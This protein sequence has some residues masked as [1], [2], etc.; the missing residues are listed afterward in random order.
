MSLSVAL[1]SLLMGLIEALH[2]KAIAAQLNGQE[3]EA[4]E[5][6]LQARALIRIVVRA[7]IAEAAATAQL[8]R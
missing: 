3:D 4:M 8:P 1:R 7:D 6:A 5:L 2:Q